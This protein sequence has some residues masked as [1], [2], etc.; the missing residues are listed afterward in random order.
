MKPGGT[1]YMVEFHPIWGVFDNDPAVSDLHVRYP[2][3]NSGEPIRTEEDGTYADRGAKVTNRLNYSWPHSDQQSHHLAN[4]GG[5]ADR[6]L[7]RISVLY[8]A[9]VSLHGGAERARL[10]PN[11]ARRLGAAHVFGEG[12]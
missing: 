3:F 11:E 9:L 5:T 1:F 4:R 7:P 10:V 2:Y 8:G 6:V 12:D